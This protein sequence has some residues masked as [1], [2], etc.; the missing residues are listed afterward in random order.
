M[1]PGTSYQPL[2][3][4]YL[5]ISKKN[6]YNECLCVCVCYLGLN[7]AVIV[8]ILELQFSASSNSKQDLFPFI[9]SYFPTLTKRIYGIIC[10]YFCWVLSSTEVQT[11]EGSQSS[12]VVQTRGL[13]LTLWQGGDLKSCGFICLPNFNDVD[14]KAKT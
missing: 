3:V 1:L 4:L 11:S 12:L 9:A 13:R 10:F 7:T 2:S 6:S 5:L 8:L 14:L